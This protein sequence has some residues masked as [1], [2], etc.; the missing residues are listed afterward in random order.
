MFWVR[1]SLVFSLSSVNPYLPS[2]SYGMVCF[3]HLLI[4]CFAFFLSKSNSFCKGLGDLFGAL[5]HIEKS[6]E[7]MIKLQRNHLE[8][9]VLH[10]WQKFFTEKFFKVFVSSFFH[11]EFYFQ[12]LELRQQLSAVLA[13][14][15]ARV[16]FSLP[17]FSPSFCCTRP[18]TGHP[19]LKT[20]VILSR[21]P[22]CSCLSWAERFLCA[23]G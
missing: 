19:A 8:K 9:I 17:L 22:S 5:F 3:Y 4:L 18:C 14:G 12:I 11:H 7:E 2:A 23:K 16:S 20:W 1:L 15:R 21:L 10:S 13:T 6:T